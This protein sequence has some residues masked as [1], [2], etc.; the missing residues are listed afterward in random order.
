MIQGV[1]A[2]Y[3]IHYPPAGSV[4]AGK[5][6]IPVQP[7]LASTMVFKH[8]IGVPASPPMESTPWYKVQFLDMMIDRLIRM[9]EKPEPVR[10]EASIDE[11][12]VAARDLMRRTASARTPFTAGLELETGGIVNTLA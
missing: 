9:G 10:R 3:L 12:I 1:S 6:S 7:L 8:V 4:M 11:R 5:L 2:A